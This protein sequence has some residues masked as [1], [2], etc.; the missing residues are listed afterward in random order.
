MKPYQPHDFAAFVGIDWAD[1]KHD[2]CLQKQGAS[3]VTLSVLPHQPEAIQRWALSLLEQFHGAP[4]AVCLELHKGPLVYALEKYPHLVLFPVNPQTVAKLRKAF[5]TSGAKDDPSDA[6]LQCDI[7]QRHFNRFSPL[8][9]QSPDIRALEQLVVY[10]RRTVADKVR[11]TNRIGS[12]LKNYFPQVLNWF[13]DIDTLIFCDFIERWP[14]LELAR[15][16]RRDVLLRFMQSHNARYDTV[17]Q[18]RV[19]DIKAAQPLTKDPGVIVPN[20]LC[21]ITLIAQLKATLQAIKLFDKNI[22]ALFHKQADR[23]LFENLPGAGPVFAPRLL[24]AFGDD[25]ARYPKPEDLQRYSGIAPVLERSGNKSWVHWRYCCPGFLR[26][27]FVEWAGETVK[28]SFWANAFYEK[29]KAKGKLHQTIIRALAY[30][31]IRILHRCWLDKKP[32]DE[33]KYLLVLK[34][35]QSPLVCLN[36]EP[37]A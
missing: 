18:K 14:S 5:A 23:N 9:P 25:R 7:L 36:P 1:K 35:K 22:A 32:Y 21:V 10:R 31:W 8:R 28:F 16:A 26:Q 6:Q 37:T 19:E 3:K 13:S 11:I 2:I 27:T 12:A 24:A 20:Q 17:N 30:K 34:K 33:A 29:Q 4:I 15:E